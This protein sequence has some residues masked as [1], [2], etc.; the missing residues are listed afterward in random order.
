MLPLLDHDAELR[1][2]AC[3]SKLRILAMQRRIARRVASAASRRQPCFAVVSFRGCLASRGGVL[4]FGSPGQ[5]RVRSDLSAPLR[6]GLARSALPHRAGAAGAPPLCKSM[7]HAVTSRPCNECTLPS[8]VRSPQVSPF[9]HLALVL[10]R[11]L[12][13][14]RR[15]RPFAAPPA[16]DP[17]VRIESLSDRRGAGRF[18]TMP[19]GP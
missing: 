14:R 18:S 4:T 7:R 12:F 1:L 9:M 16:C 3:G 19:E 10:L 11:C 15:R 17:G 6:V 5:S 8:P 13:A 2:G